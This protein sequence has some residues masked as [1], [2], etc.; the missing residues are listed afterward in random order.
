MSLVD[1]RE[2]EILADA[3]ESLNEGFEHLPETAADLDTAAIA[4]VLQR[5]ARRMHDNYPYCLR[6]AAV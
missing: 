1:R 4:A 5:V 2:L 6:M 3:L